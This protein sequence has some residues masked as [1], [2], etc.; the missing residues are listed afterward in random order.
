MCMCLTAYV[1]VFKDACMFFLG[2]WGGT[3][4]ADF[5]AFNLLRRDSETS[6]FFRRSVSR[7]V[8]CSCTCMRRRSVRLRWSGARQLTPNYCFGCF[9]RALLASKKEGDRE[10]VTEG[11]CVCAGVG[12]SAGVVVCSP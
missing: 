1:Y 12:V 6:S 2:G 5:E 10:T 7:L 4:R 8:T 9:S 11:E 3:W